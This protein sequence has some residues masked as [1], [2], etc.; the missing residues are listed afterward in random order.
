M[1]NN[2]LLMW[3][4]LLNKRLYKKATFIVILALIPI[5]VFGYNLLSEGE[6]GIV[7]VALANE[8]DDPLTEAIFAD[9]REDSQLV[10][11]IEC[12]SDEEAIRLVEAGKVDSAW[13]FPSQMSK[14]MAAFVESGS[15]RD[16]VVRVLT[17]ENNVLLMLAGEKLSGTLFKSAAETFYLNFAREQSEVLASLSDEE[18]LAYYDAVNTTDQL[19]SF[20]SIEGGST[21]ESTNS[22]HYL[23]APVRGLLAVVTVLCGL[24]TAMYYMQDQRFGTF[25]QLAE[26]K[27]P[28]AELG[29]QLISILNVSVAVLISLA[30]SGMASSPIKEL[31]ALLLYAP[32]TAAFCMVIRRLCGNLRALSTLLPL[33]IVAMIAICPIFFDLGALRQLQ[34]LFPPTYYINAIYNS[35][36]YLYM[37][38][39]TI[40]AFTVYFLTGKLF[41]RT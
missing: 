13:L 5:L 14:R 24:A 37:L 17:R 29:C 25:S 35:K 18:L 6:S 1:K 33:L 9:L 32:C 3:F 27:R 31:V 28:L 8:S 38:F 41:R 40:A 7:T 20:D 11:Y 2:R 15:E 12:E 10:R 30:L 26:R 23:T 19:F 39:Y 34:Y 36:Y 16:A 22:S 21:E 4:L